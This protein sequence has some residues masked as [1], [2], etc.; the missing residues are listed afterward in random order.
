MFK[1]PKTINNPAELSTI[2]TNGTIKYLE[3]IFN[4]SFTQKKINFVEQKNL[5]TKL[6]KI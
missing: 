4:I 1:K 5:L 3:N 6:T 2:T